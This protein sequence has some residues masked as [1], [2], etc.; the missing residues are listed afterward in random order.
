MSNPNRK[1]IVRF[2][3]IVTCT[4][5]SSLPRITFQKGFYVSIGLGL[6]PGWGPS[7]H[8]TSGLLKKLC[9]TYRFSLFASVRVVFMAERERGSLHDLVY[10]V[11]VRFDS[12]DSAVVSS[13]MLREAY[14]RMGS[15][16]NRHW[17]KFAR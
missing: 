2:R 16:R 9:R 7:S 3:T 17:S 13:V 14:S 6:H 4:R 11:Y 1:I 12:Q 8:C 15:S 5:V 10:G